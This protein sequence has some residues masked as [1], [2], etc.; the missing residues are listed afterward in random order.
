MVLSK[1]MLRCVDELW[2]RGVSYLYM[3]RVYLLTRN[4]W[5]S[6]YPPTMMDRYH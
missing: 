3:F 6:T 4:F 1:T 2:C 5:P